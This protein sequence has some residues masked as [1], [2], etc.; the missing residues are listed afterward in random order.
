[1]VRTVRLRGHVDENG[2]LTVDVPDDIPAGEVEVIVRSRVADAD[3]IPDQPL[4]RETIRRKLRTSGLLATYRPPHNVL[5]LSAEE[6]L[7]LGTLPPD[8]PSSAQLID[9]DRGEY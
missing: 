2:K 5:A 1:M 9:E 6:I 3:D 4:S 8:A 7:W